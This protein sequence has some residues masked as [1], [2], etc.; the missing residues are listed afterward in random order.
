MGYITP[1]HSPPPYIGSLFGQKVP[2]VDSWLLSERGCHNAAHCCCCTPAVTS[3]SSA[4]RIDFKIN[5]IIFTIL[6]FCWFFCSPHGIIG[7]GEYPTVTCMD[8]INMIFYHAPW[9]P[10]LCMMNVVVIRQCSD[11]YKWTETDSLTG[12]T[13]VAAG[14]PRD[15]KQLRRQRV[16][17]VFI[18]FFERDPVW[19]GRVVMWWACWFKRGGIMRPDHN[20]LCEVCLL[21]CF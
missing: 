2:Q 11:E 17:Q 3:W 8:C 15:W 20:S 10:F 18:S 21:G 6:L 14:Q 9:S 19:S 4:I 1:P 12:R 16:G 7:F 5:Q 13:R